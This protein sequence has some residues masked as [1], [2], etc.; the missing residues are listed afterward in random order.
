MNGAQQRTLVVGVVK[1]CDLVGGHGNRATVKIAWSSQYVIVSHPSSAG[2]DK[3]SQ[4]MYSACGR[5][6]P[7]NIYIDRGTK[8]KSKVELFKRGE[9]YKL[10]KGIL[11]DAL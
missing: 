10:K 6:P 4:G 8:T 7:G 2:C 9:G 11:I 5:V 1:S 3:V